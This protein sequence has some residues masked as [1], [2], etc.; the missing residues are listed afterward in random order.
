VEYVLREE[1][2]PAGGP[3][4]DY[5]AELNAEQ[6]EAVTAP[7]GPILVIAGAGS[8]KTRTLTY[9]V[10][11]LVEQ[12]VAPEQ[13]LLLTFTNKASKE[14]LAR[15][16]S[17]L[18]HDL[19]RL[20]GG[21]FHHVGNRILRRHADRVGYA[22][23][24][25]ILDRED[26]ED[27]ISASLGEAG[28]DPKDKRFPKPEVLAE[29]FSLAANHRTTVGTILKKQFGYFTELESWIGKVAEIYLRRK[30]DSG[31]M[32]YDDL[33]T[34]SLQILEQ[35]DLRERYRA[36]FQH[37]LVDE[38]Q[39]TNRLQS[40]FV[41]AI[42]A[43]HHQIMAVGD[44]AQSIYSWRGA[45]VEHILSF[46]ER[47]PGTKVVRLETNYRSIPQIL[48]LANHAISHNP[49]Q[50]PKNLRAVREA[51]VK[52][53]LVAVEDGG[54]Q[55]A[56]VAQRILELHE[57][58]TSLSDIAI[59]YRAHFHA[60]EMQLELTRRN[61]PYTIT[62]GL[63][64]FE[65]AHIK[66]V[67]AHLRVGANAKDEVAFHRLARLLPG[68][69]P[70]SATKMWN[71]VAGGKPLGQVKVS[72]KSAKGWAQLVE[73]LRQIAGK[74]P[75]EQVKLVVEGSYGDYVRARYANAVNR[76][77]DLRQLEDYAN[78]FANTADFLAE[79]ALLGNTETEVAARQGDNE[80]EAVRLSTVHQ[81]K[82]L[83]Y[84]VVF[85]IMLCDGLFP[86]ARAMETEEGEEEERRLFYVAVTRA[87]DE[88]Y[89]SH[90]R[91]RM[92]KGG[93]AWQTPSRFLNELN[94]DLVNVW[95]VKGAAGLGDWS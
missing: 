40:D 64:F 94:R 68:V 22:K 88:L 77:D 81:A 80:G 42:G 28:V 41:D 37:V 17:L 4:I 89:L 49:K 87:K 36:R 39:D 45:K 16:A 83:E 43:G 78:G 8:G 59:L 10:A 73:T 54:Q 90:P 57:E 69:G 47:H 75:A 92:G 14:M 3:G 29:I 84:G 30:R 5:A 53:A 32:D 55:A 70:K 31:A 20:W 7:P 51:G 11:Y 18:P 27:L 24:Y 79:L 65:Q 25:T 52:P 91:L 15:V 67:A 66:D 82:G 23:D 85:V 71:E 63:R 21:T 46:P 56:F 72:E 74:P 38:Y 86:S 60:M 1:G 62:S 34:L 48:E 93:D 76:L 95:R 26:A 44:D 9:R 19:S 12:G 33:L 2:R 35:P 6:L 61:I 58:G 50:F 13:I